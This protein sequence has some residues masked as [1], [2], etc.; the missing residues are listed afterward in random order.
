MSD[1]VGMRVQ[2]RGRPCFTTKPAGILKQPIEG[3]DSLSFC[4]PKKRRLS[5]EQQ[6]AIFRQRP[7]LVIDDEF[8]LVDVIPDFLHHG[9]DVVVVGDGL[10]A[11]ALYL[12]RHLARFD[13]FVHRSEEHTSEL[14]SP[15]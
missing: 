11:F 3:L 10:L 15:S 1:C 13:D 7:H 9:D 6:F 2:K 12:V 14:Q 8:Q 5:D 4:Y